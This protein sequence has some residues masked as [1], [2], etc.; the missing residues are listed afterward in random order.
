MHVH[1]Y[2]VDIGGESIVVRV[3]VLGGGA[4]VVWAGRE[5]AT[6]GVHAPLGADAGAVPAPAVPGA[7][8]RDF[9]VAMAQPRAGDSGAQSGAPGT[10]LSHAG[11]LALPVSYT[12]LTLPTNRE[13]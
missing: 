2:G 12:H 5:S 4:M 9:A 6:S 8:M 1:T 7:L 3:S 13:V 10:A 11:D